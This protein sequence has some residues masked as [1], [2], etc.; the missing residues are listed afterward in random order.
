VSTPTLVVH[1]D[2]C[3]LPDN[4]RAVANDLAGP[5]DVVWA[6]GSQIDFYDQDEQVSLAVSA[7]AKHFGKTL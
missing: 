3:V 2:D 6:T 4:V 5:S 7:A 1:S